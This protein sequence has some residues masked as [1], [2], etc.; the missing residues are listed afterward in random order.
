[1]HKHRWALL[2]QGK[3]AAMSLRR[4]LDFIKGRQTASSKD[5]QREYFVMT[6]PLPIMHTSAYLIIMLALHVYN[7]DDIY[8]DFHVLVGN[9]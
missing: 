9:S 2:F 5:I 3:N 4:V 7:Y 8:A 6:I 1:M